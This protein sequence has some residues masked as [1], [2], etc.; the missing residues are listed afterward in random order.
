MTTV[1]PC[2]NTCHELK[3][4]TLSFHFFKIP[5][6]SMSFIHDDSIGT[7]ML[8]CL[9]TVNFSKIS[10]FSKFYFHFNVHGIQLFFMLSKHDPLISMFRCLSIVLK[11]SLFSAH[12]AVH[13]ICVY[14]ENKNLP[15][16]A[17]NWRFS[18]CAENT[19]ET[20]IKINIAYSFSHGKIGPHNGDISHG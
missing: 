17:E 3:T 13:E 20:A 2:A 1:F 9:F 12:D 11:I 5:L 19:M 4:F 18:A 15:C 8:H 14:F 16:I 6:F 7:I 10:L